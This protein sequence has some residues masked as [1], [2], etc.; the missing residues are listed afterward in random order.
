MGIC[1]MLPGLMKQA[2]FCEVA[3]RSFHLDSSTHSPLHLALCK[4]QEIALAL[5]QPALLRAGVIEEAEYE[6]LRT[7]IQLDMRNEDFVCVSF[8]V[9]V[10]GCAPTTQENEA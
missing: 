4:N 10:W 9:Q 8:G 7:Q 2:G 3:S 5:L 6:A 1:P